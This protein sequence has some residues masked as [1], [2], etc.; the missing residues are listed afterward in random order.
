[1]RPVRVYLDTSDYASM[2][3]PDAPN[4]TKGILTYL[5]ERINQGKIEIGYSAWIVL[6]FIQPSDDKYIEDRRERG[7]F[8]KYLCGQNAFPYMKD[9]SSGAEFPN[10]GRWV[11]ASAARA[12][13]G[14]ALDK[15]LQQ[16]LLAAL[17]G[18]LNLSRA[19][20]NSLG[21]SKAIQRLIAKNIETLKI[22]PDMVK[23]LPAS[24]EIFRKRVFEH[25]LCGKISANT[26]SRYL[27]K[28]M[29]DPENF[30]E[31]LNWY[32]GQDSPVASIISSMRDDV[33]AKLKNVAFDYAAVNKSWSEYLKIRADVAAN[34]GVSSKQLDSEVDNLAPSKLFENLDTKK[35]DEAFGNGR[36][37]FLVCYF[38]K[39]AKGA[40]CYSPGDM[41]DLM[42]LFYAKD[43]DVFRC[44]KRMA[45]IMR[46]CQVLK[47]SNL[48]GSLVELPKAIDKVIDKRE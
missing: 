37:L 18:Q 24:E 6:E 29:N 25:Y 46:D 48:V 38:E 15:T 42:H 12:F 14:P 9:V 17:K 20:R 22:T 32:G 36:M 34:L 23:Q 2:Y 13:S 28:W 27:T 5:K 19:Q 41:G 30:G 8:I 4:E 3:R 44:D 33:Q 16:E 45:S 10:N 21:G 40:I 47:D 1:M 39:I 35:L 11:P 26:L 31:L 7:R 43:C